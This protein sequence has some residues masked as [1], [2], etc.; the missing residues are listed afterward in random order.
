MKPVNPM[1][2]VRKYNVTYT[3]CSQA[4]S[5]NHGKLATIP[6]QLHC[7]WKALTKQHQLFPSRKKIKLK[8]M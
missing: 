4:G 7:W 5:L 2:S 8:A 6:I 1:D 3:V